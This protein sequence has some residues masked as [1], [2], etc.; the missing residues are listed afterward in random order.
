MFLLGY[1]NDAL[2]LLALVH[3]AAIYPVADLYFRVVYGGI[4]RQ[5]KNILVLRH[6]RR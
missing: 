2:R 6:T 4:V 5:Q 3:L 1:L